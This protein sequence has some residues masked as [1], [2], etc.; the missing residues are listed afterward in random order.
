MLFKIDE[1]LPIEF[2][3]LLLDAGHDAKTVNDQRNTASLR[4]LSALFI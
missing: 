3:R 2:A 1:N 4:L